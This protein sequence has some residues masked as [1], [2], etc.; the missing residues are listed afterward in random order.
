M[1]L[2]LKIL[3]IGFLLLLL[4]AVALTLVL[5]SGLAAGCCGGHGSSGGSSSGEMLLFWL[6]TGLFFCALPFLLSGITAASWRWVGRLFIAEIALALVGGGIVALIVW[7]DER[8]SAYDQEQIESF[9]PVFKARSAAVA[10]AFD[11]DD[12]GALKSAILAC[13]YYVK[14][15][16]EKYRGLATGEG[17]VRFDER[18][19]QMEQSI[20]N[21]DLHEFERLL[22]L[23]EFQAKN[24]DQIL[25]QDS[26]GAGSLAPDAC[27]TGTAGIADRAWQPLEKAHLLGEFTAILARHR[28]TPLRV[29]E[30]MLQEIFLQALNQRRA[31]IAQAVLD[32][33]GG[34]FRWCRTGYGGTFNSGTF[35]RDSSKPVWLE[36]ERLY[37]EAIADWPQEYWTDIAQGYLGNLTHALA[38]PPE[39]RYDK[40]ENRIPYHSA[41]C[42]R[43]I[44]RILKTRPTADRAE[45]KPRCDF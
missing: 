33:A 19:S 2:R 26:Y 41:E 37:F 45:L 24:L 27:N 32:Q 38:P 25:L 12:I 21:K 9:E 35:P 3:G 34:R 14:T 5:L 44:E 31:D 13:Q 15:V 6:A 8:E 18:V 4:G 22:N 43:A 17:R 23:T 11:A 16:P 40:D 10:A 20:E 7:N 28:D 1:A 42:E 39:K 30:S 29:G 36:G